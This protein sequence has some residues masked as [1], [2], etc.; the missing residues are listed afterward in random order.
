MHKTYNDDKSF[1]S[2]ELSG[3]IIVNEM[4]LRI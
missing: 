1:I 2:L 3:I 4:L